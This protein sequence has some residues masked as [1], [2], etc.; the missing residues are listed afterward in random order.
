[1]ATVDHQFTIH[2]QSHPWPGAR[3]G[4]QQLMRRFPSTDDALYVKIIIRGDKTGF[5]SD[6][7]TLASHGFMVEDLSI[8][9]APN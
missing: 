8:V 3:Y 7:E 4:M 6:I 1:M 5:E 2:L 9:A